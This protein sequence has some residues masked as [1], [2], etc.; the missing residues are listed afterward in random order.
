V[1]N[2]HRVAENGRAEEVPFLLGMGA[3]IDEWD[4]YGRTPLGIAA[5]HGNTEVARALIEFGADPDLEDYEGYTPT[6]YAVWG[7]HYEALLALLE[8][9]TDAQRARRATS[10]AC[11]AAEYGAAVLVKRLLAWGVDVN[12]TDETGLPLLMYATGWG[13]WRGNSLDAER[14]EAVRVLLEHGADVSKRHHDVTAVYGAAVRGDVEM[15]R[16][17]QEAGAS[18]N[19]PESAMIGDTETVRRLLDLEAD[20]NARDPDENGTALLHAARGG[21][22]TTVRLLLE[23]GADVFATDEYGETPLYAA[24]EAGRAAVAA[25][26]VDFGAV[27]NQ[28]GALP[29]AVAGGHTEMAALLLGR[30]ASVNERTSGGD[31]P[32]MTAARDGLSNIVQLFIAAGADVN[33]VNDFGYTALMQ[34]AERGALQSARLLLEA[35]ADVS[36]INIH[37]GTALGYAEY[38]GHGELANL[39]RAAGATE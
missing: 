20:V 22:V 32:L 25:I 3:K 28:D 26:L 13:R 6:H 29:V 37:G 12:A 23:R 16:L 14:R 17:L 39:L 38:Q 27:K 34:A 19:L 9:G 15:V 11:L 21:H 35:G 10:A 1:D 7:R 24:A 8:Y 2:L 18:I 31:T 30:D 4:D 5:A 33:A 36:K